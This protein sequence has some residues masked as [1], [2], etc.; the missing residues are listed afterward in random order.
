MGQKFIVVD[1]DFINNMLCRFIIEKAFPGADI[2]TY[3]EPETALVYI[4]ATCSGI[5]SGD[6]VLFLDI[7]MPTLTGW[8]FLDAFEKFDEDIKEKLKIYMLSSSVD[9][10]DKARAVGNKNV[11]D[12][13]EK[14][15]SREALERVAK[16]A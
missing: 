14:P 7:N 11:L 4:Q 1:D 8:E 5:H 15:L 2:Q 13:M 12:Y 3:T 9:P 6:T 16:R 10:Q